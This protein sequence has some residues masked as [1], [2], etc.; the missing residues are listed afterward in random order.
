MGDVLSGR[1]LGVSAWR[2]VSLGLLALAGALMLPAY[3]SAASI[4]LPG[5]SSAAQVDATEVSSYQEDFEVSRQTAEESL[6]AQEDGAGI[7]EALESLQGEDYAG[8]WFDNESG[9]FVVPVVPGTDTASISTSLAASDLATDFRT[10]P[11]SSSWDE[12]EAAQKRI[13]GALSALI[14]EGLVGTSLDPRT[15]SVVISQAEAA[16]ASQRAEIQAA[17]QGEDV[18]VEVRESQ[19]QRL[20]ISTQACQFGA[21]ICDA[22]MRGGVNIVPNG[23]NRG[24]GGCTAAF[25]GIGDVYGNRFVLTAGHCVTETGAL[26]WDSFLPAPEERKDLGHVDA[27]SFPNHDYAAINANGTYWDKPSWPSEVVY[28]G[29]NQEYPI[30]NESSSYVGE[31]VCHIGQQS[32]LSCGGVTAMQIT[33]PVKDQAG[34][35]LG[36]VNGLT[37][38]EHICTIPGDSG[39]PVF[40]PGNIALGIYSASDR[41][42]EALNS[43][44]WNGYYTEITEDTDLLGVHV[45]PRIAPPP[46]PPPPAQPPVKTAFVDTG[47]AN[48]LTAWEFGSS[49][50]QQLFLWGHPVAAGTAP[51]VMSYGG[52]KHIF[53]VDSSRGNQITEW[54]WN[55]TTG[56]QQAFLATDPVASGSSVTGAVANGSPKLFFSDAT[57]NRSITALSLSGGSWSQSK[58]YG[59]PVAVNSSPS[60]ISNNGQPQVYFVDSAKGNTIAV[61]TWGATIQQ[62]FF[63]GDPV[64][65]NSSPSA[66]S[67]NGQAQVYFADSAKSNTIAVWTWGATIQQSFFYGDSVATNSSPSALS[68]NGT[69]HVYFAD[70]SKGRTI[71]VWV[72]TPTSIQQSFF[73]GDWVATNSSPSAILTGNGAD[74][75]FFSDENTNRS[76]ALW[77]WGS[78]LQQTRLYGHLALAGTSPGA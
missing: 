5:G 34:N 71:S 11:V 7:V 61:W 15:N 16:N 12:L 38:F 21:S 43:C 63:Y 27:Y 8:V 32:G 51:F 6:E 68:A 76:V 50:W 60:A 52:T 54:S 70:G 33:E 14:E 59:D 28:W 29:V 65:A 19:E 67:N 17:A 1:W 62:S 44:Y 24:P 41:P 25:K 36:Y 58:F 42:K 2:I 31:Y 37:K 39:G 35:V 77:E 22:P 30:N 69:P 45:A 78:T 56:W 57:T 75:V 23:A 4:D 20:G 13:N 64:A 48:S 66:I 46:P 3:A 47:D 72:W 40:T 74:Q 49:G 10:K 26:K 55:P 18:A 73:G 53:F 9:E